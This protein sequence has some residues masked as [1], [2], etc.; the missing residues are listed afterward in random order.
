MLNVQIGGRYIEQGDHAKLLGVMIDGSMSWE[1][2]INTICCMVS[3]RLSLLHGIK[4]Y[5]N[6]G[7]ASITLVL[8]TTLFIVL[9]CGKTASTISSYNSFVFR[10]MLGV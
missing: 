6:F 5:L 7:S 4:F 10:S 9:L 1:H 2:H 3:S 8:T